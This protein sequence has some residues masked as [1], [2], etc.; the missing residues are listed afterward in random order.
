VTTGHGPS[1]EWSIEDEGAMKNEKL[2]ILKEWDEH[3]RTVHPRQW[4]REEKKRA[5]RLRSRT[6]S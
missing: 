1:I 3:L 2:A 4:G 5:R 6:R